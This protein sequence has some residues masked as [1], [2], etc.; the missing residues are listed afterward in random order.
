MN[1]TPD[2]IEAQARGRRRL[3]KQK[4]AANYA[5]FDAF[6]KPITYRHIEDFMLK[7]GKG[8]RRIFG[9]INV[10]VTSH[11]GQLMPAPFRKLERVGPAISTHICQEPPPLIAL[12]RQTVGDDGGGNAGGERTQ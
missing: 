7:S 4:L 6:L 10:A 5:A 2:P 12:M 8:R 9:R 1:R 3:Y 11:S